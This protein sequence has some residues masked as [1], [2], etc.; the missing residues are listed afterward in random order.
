MEDLL[1]EK[2][3][4]KAEKI[5]NEFKKTAKSYPYPHEVESERDLMKIALLFENSMLSRRLLQ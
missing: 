4:A 2:N 3:P 5:Q 1:F